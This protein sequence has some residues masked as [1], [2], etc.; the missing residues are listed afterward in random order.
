LLFCHHAIVMACRF[1]GVPLYLFNAS[2]LR[3]FDVAALYDFNGV[4]SQCHNAVMV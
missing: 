2:T 4:H 1:D 3:R